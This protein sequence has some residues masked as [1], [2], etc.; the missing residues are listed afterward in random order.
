M[1]KQVH[2]RIL[3]DIE[4]VGIKETWQWLQGGSITKSMED[5]IWLHT[6]KP[7]EPGGLDAGFERKM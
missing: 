6:S 1:K 3:N 5:L 7:N 4:Q 2:G